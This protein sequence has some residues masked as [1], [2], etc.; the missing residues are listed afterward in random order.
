M[1]KK[2]IFIS[3][4]ICVCVIFIFVSLAVPDLSVEKI[5]DVKQTLKIFDKDKNEVIS[6]NAGENREKVELSQISPNVINALIATED[7][8]FYQHNGIDIKRIFGALWADMKAQSAKEGAS[9]ITQQLIKN[10]HLTNEKTISRK[11]NEA[12]LALQI[13]SRYSKD[14]ILEMY[15]NFVYFGRGA[16]GIQ[17]AAKQYFGKNADE[18]SLAEAA[19]LVGVLKAPSKY[20]PHLDYQASKK[21]RAVVLKQMQKYGYITEEEYLLSSKEEIS[22]IEKE[23]NFDYGYYTDYIITEAAQKLNI[24]VADLLGGG[25]NVYTSLNSS[26]QENLQQ[27]FLQSE[28]FPDELVESAS[29]VIDNSDGSI[30][31]LIGGREHEAMRIYNRATAKRQPGSCIKPILVYAPALESGKYTAAT[32]LEDYRKSFNGYTPTNFKDAYYGK[33]TLRRALALSLNV[34]AVEILLNNGI[35]YSKEFV[36]KLNIKF[37]SSDVNPALALGGMKYGISPLELASAYSCF[38][39]DGVYKNYWCIEKIT[40]SSEEVL[41][42]HAQEEVKVF[43]DS[44]AFIITDIMRDVAKSTSLASYNLDIACKTGTVGYNK[45]GYSDAWCTGYT[46]NYSVSV[47]L[48]YDKTTDEAYLP[49]EITGSTYPTILLG[50]ILS[51][52]DKEPQSFQAPISTVKV[53][54]DLYELEKS[55]QLCLASEKTPKNFIKAEYFAIDNQPTSFSENW[56]IPQ[57]LK[58]DETFF[59]E[60]RNLVISFKSQ[61]DQYVYKIY[62]KRGENEILLVSSNKSIDEKIS[63]TDKN[64]KEGDEYFVIVEHKL[65]YTDLEKS[66][67]KRIK[68]VV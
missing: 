11:I 57:T 6:L 22:V 24:S 64:Y 12:I 44:T 32:M 29:V 30:A 39:N 4:I 20:A 61:G 13:E 51:A 66:N 42:E 41:Y 15:L 45:L 58:Q 47:W 18:L 19:T 50:K 31:A 35:E 53:N 65:L 23:E 52:A 34:P 33:V 21:R 1:K 16:Y 25:Y 68:I 28:N 55:G 38:A 46:K 17:T 9:T 27:I 43:S 62:K 67:S 49:E 36:K 60:L 10:S 26:L 3:I 40:N 59:D 48:G 37:D 54:V 56:N 14:E 8:R 5:T 7:I 63:V 2:I